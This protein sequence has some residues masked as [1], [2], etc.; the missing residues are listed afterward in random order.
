[1]NREPTGAQLMESLVADLQKLGYSPRQIA[2]EC[3]VSHNTVWRASVGQAT[4]PLWS[5]FE[6]LRDFHDRVKG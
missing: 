5:T 3:G 2:K 6:K 1:M 4:A